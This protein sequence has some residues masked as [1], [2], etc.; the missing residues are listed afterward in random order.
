MSK[1]RKEPDFQEALL[2]KFDDY[3]SKGYYE[4]VGPLSSEPRTRLPGEVRSYI[5][6]HAVVTPEKTRLVADA[7]AKCPDESGTR[8]CLNDFLLRGP[9]DGSTL[10]GCMLRFRLHEIAF[11]ADIGDMFHNVRNELRDRDAIRTV[12]PKL[13]DEELLLYV[14]RGACHLFGTICANFCSAHALQQTAERLGQHAGQ[15]GL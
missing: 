4:E 6:I 5:P 15:S 14:F 10:I 12:F 13:V 11:C 3:V 1:M 7:A 8:V 2:T 9:N